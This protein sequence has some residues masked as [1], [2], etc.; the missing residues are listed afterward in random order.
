M[1][2]L[3]DL[4]RL[5]QLRKLN[6]NPKW[7]NTDL[8]RLLYRKGLYA[9]AYQQ[10]TAKAGSPGAGKATSYGS[11]LAE[12]EDTIKQLRDE[13][14][15]PA[16]VQQISV[17]GFH[18]KLRDKVLQEVLRLV[19]EAIY[20]SPD[21]PLFESTSHG[22]RKG[23]SP[24]TALKE[25]QRTWSGVNWFIT[26]DMRSCFDELNQEKL[27]E[28]LGAK[29]QDQRFLNLVRKLLKSGYIDQEWR[30]R[31]S[32][33]G[34]PQGGILSPLL[35]NVLLD[36]LD[37]FVEQLRETHEKG[38]A[39]RA[40]REYRALV[41]QRQVLATQGLAKSK[42][43]RQ[44]VRQLREMPSLDPNDEGF[45]RLKY[46]RYADTWLI[47]IT[48]SR[49]FAE[50][51]RENISEFLKN[52]LKQTPGDD[53]MRIVHARTGQ[54]EFLGMLI[55]IGRVSPTGQRVVPSTSA[56][57]PQPQ[58]RPPAWEVIL[59][60]PIDDLIRRL[61]EKGFCDANGKPQGKG[62]YT[63]LDAG[64]SILR[65]SSINR[66]LQQ[67]YRVCD[68]FGELTR[69][70][71]VLKYSLAKTLAE[72]YRKSV[73]RILQD[74]EIKHIST[75]SKGEQKEVRFS[76]NRNWRRDRSAW[77]T[78]PFIDQA[79]LVAQRRI[80]RQLPSVCVLCGEEHHVAMHHV[81]HLRRLDEKRKD[82]TGLTRI[83]GTFN[84]KQ[85]PLCKECYNAVH[86]G[87]YG[88]PKR[89]GLRN[90]PQ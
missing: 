19:M 47:G 64:Q 48:G 58:G 36:R 76:I 26:G 46:V 23:R 83:I 2:A 84:R 11:L 89:T 61:A 63:S 67:Y 18:G 87:D 35:A 80:H 3:R 16:S 9:V 59:Q 30:G 44:I 13:S 42:E 60:C 22:F 82:D 68:N 28:I 53:K 90:D 14:Y 70:Q 7:R 32:L 17:P 81:R 39:R 1:E 88:R 8:Y 74:G 69:V 66:G 20:D 37:K 79:G 57:G 75:T 43:F 34:I 78:K 40:S 31:N 55:S 24:H 50:V 29:I 56:G 10:I 38:K 62:A 73:A 12:I 51:I 21:G 33:I 6:A 5:A 27:I 65:Y 71:Y 72:K 15:Q 41:A 85:L 54:A 45:I 77:S 52:E 25:V 4:E 49:Q 86:G